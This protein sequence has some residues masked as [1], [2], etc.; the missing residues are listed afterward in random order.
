MLLP[1]FRPVLIAHR[2]KRGQ[3]GRESG[4]TGSQFLQHRGH[5]LSQFIRAMAGGKKSAQ[6]LR[7]ERHL[8]GIRRNE[9]IEL[10]LV[11]DD[12]AAA[13]GHQ[14]LTEQIDTG[15]GNTEM[16]FKPVLLHAVS[17]AENREKLQ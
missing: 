8:V 12:A 16:N 15:G 7:S 4:D 1:A 14:F 10:P 17:L 2:Q 6:G 3:V 13:E 5:L 11:D 9:G